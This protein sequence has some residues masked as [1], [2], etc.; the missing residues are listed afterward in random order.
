MRNAIRNGALIREDEAVVPVTLREVQYSYSIYEALSVKNGNAV[1]LDDHLRRLR[2]SAAAIG[3]EIPFSDDDIAEALGL[4]IAHDGILDCTVRLFMVGGPRPVYFITYSDLLAYPDSY[5]TEGVGASLYL[6]ERFLP[7]AKTS[8]LLMQYIALEEARK[9]GSFEA[10][11]VD[12]YGRVLEGTRSNFYAVSGSTVYTAS[13]D[14]VLSGITRMSVIRACRELG[15]SVEYLPP[16]YRMLETFD[17]LF[18]SSTSMG[19]MPLRSV[20]GKEMG[21]TAWDK[22]HQIHALVREW[23]WE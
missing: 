22:I 6:G 16:A 15:F 9:A 21:R 5:Y 3:M 18:I 17:S 4:L 12:R 13:D 10:L 11:L 23:E 1:H 2:D 8:N 14:L 19:A 7:Q 20:D